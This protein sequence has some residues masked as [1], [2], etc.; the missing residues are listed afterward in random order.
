MGISKAADHTKKV[1]LKKN[2]T[3]QKD[4]LKGIHDQDSICG[5]KL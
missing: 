2:N 4:I 5:G 3:R 1:G